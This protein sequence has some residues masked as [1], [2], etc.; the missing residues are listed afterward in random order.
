MIQEVRYSQSLSHVECS[1]AVSS[2]PI[3][4]ILTVPFPETGHII[5]PAFVWMCTLMAS[6]KERPPV[7]PNK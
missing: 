4:K 2:G 6:V 1:V 5:L 3:H 7:C